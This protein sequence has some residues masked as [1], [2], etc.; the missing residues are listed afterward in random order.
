MAVADNILKNFN[1]FVDGRGYVGNVD[2]LTLPN[3][4][5][6]LEDFRAGGMDAPIGIDMG[7]EKLEA[8][9]GLTDSGARAM[10]LYGVNRRGR[11]VPLTA[12]GSLESQSGEKTPVLVQME[13]T[14][15]GLEPDEWKS[16]EKVTNKYTVQLVSYKY[17]VGGE[18]IHHIDIPNMIRIIDG[19]DQL[20]ETRANLGM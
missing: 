18:L 13:G 11:G 4:S 8:S 2:S 1:L 9:F 12:R 10:R 7:M 20:A 5:L 19:N 14:I 6:K 15:S 17:S 3:L 16:G